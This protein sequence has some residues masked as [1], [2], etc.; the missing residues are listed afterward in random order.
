MVYCT[1]FYIFYCYHKSRYHCAQG[2]YTIHHQQIFQKYEHD[3]PQTLNTYVTN[4]ITAILGTDRW[5]NNPALSPED[6]AALGQ[7]LGM[8]FEDARADQF[9]Y[10]DYT[11]FRQDETGEFIVDSYGERDPF[12]SSIATQLKPRKEFDNAIKNLILQKM[13]ADGYYVKIEDL[14]ERPALRSGV[15]LRNKPSIRSYP[16]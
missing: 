6:I 9:M 4:E 7:V 13:V 11:E 14:I 12:L 3:A 16:R 10:Q 15:I 8:H 5:Q 1:F 2:R